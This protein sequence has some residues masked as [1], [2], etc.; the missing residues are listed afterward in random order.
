M[1][2]FEKA[3]K[4]IVNDEALSREDVLKKTELDLKGLVF[5]DEQKSGVESIVMQYLTMYMKAKEVGC[6]EIQAR[7]AAFECL[8]AMF[9]GNKQ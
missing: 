3:R 8:K 2:Y 4:A 6:D 9:A 7:L 1:E 5:N